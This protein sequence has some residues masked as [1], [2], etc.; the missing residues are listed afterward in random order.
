MRLILC[1]LCKKKIGGESGLYT[2]EMSNNVHGVHCYGLL[3]PTIRPTEVC[4]D[5]A[6]KIK[7]FLNDLAVSGSDERKQI[8]K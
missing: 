3:L 5:C 2:I 6:D 4:V 7:N 1:D 8:V